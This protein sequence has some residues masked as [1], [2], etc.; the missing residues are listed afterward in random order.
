MVVLDNCVPLDRDCHALAVTSDIIACP[1]VP[2][3]SI[4]L[5]SEQDERN[6]YSTATPLRIV[7]NLLGNLL[8][9]PIDLNSF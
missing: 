8:R 2:R 5:I 3:F 6:L 1:D 7:I 9:V 4:Y